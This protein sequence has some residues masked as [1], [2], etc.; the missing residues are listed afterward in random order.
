MCGDAVAQ[1]PKYG[2]P[3]IESPL[4]LPIS[5]SGT[6]QQGTVCRMTLKPEKIQHTPKPFLTRALHTRK[7]GLPSSFHPAKSPKASRKFY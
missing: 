7:P 6:I 4:R 5:V 1:S 3:P 2:F